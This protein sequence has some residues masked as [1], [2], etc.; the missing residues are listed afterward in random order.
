MYDHRLA[1]V[2]HQETI[3]K[4]SSER[5]QKGTGNQNESMGMRKVLVAVISILNLWK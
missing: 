1:Q 2:R 5:R 3:N 4:A